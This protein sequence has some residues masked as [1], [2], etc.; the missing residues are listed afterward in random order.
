MK[1]PNLDPSGGYLAV[2][3]VLV[4]YDGPQIFTLKNAA[5]AIF[6]AVHGPAIESVDTWLFVRTSQY[7]LTQLN[8]GA[9]TLRELLTLYASGLP[10]IVSYPKSDPIFTFIDSSQI[11]NEL[12]PH[13]DSYMA[14]PT[15]KSSDLA[16]YNPGNKSVMAPLEDDDIAEIPFSTEMTLWEFNPETIEYFRSNMTPLNVVARRRGRLVADI[17]FSSGDS[18]T[19]FPVPELGKILINLQKTLDSLGSDV[20]SSTPTGRPSAALKKQTRLDAVATF[21][22]SFGLRVEAHQ[23]SLVE[24]ARSDIA[25]Y[26]FVDLLSTVTD[27]QALQQA[28]V[29]ESTETKLYFGE[30]IKEV[31]KTGSSIKVSVGSAYQEEIGVVLVPADAVAKLSRDISY[32]NEQDHID[33]V[34]EGRLRAVSLK[35]KF[36][37][38]ESDDDSWSGRISESLMS[39][40]SGSEINAWYRASITQKTILHPITGEVETKNLLTALEKLAPANP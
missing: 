3:D 40:V 34:I 5:G 32:I 33:I 30:V 4:E 37:L 23:G 31:A 13:Y 26:K 14:E 19:D 18:R 12:L 1:L 36:F 2:R 22:S 10:A 28:F 25:F 20:D 35:T 8:R 24:D 7:R 29:R 17:V 38:V 27:T 16:L 15:D 11:P 9:I 21:P 6:I 39:Q